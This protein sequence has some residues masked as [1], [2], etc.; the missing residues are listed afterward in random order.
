[1]KQEQTLSRRFTVSSSIVLTVLLVIVFTGLFLNTNH[2][3][4]KMIADQ[5]NQL[6]EN[7]VSKGELLGNLTS[8]ITPELVMGGDMFT[9]KTIA[10]Q[11]LAD[12]DVSSVEI[13]DPSGKQLLIETEKA[14]SDSLLVV[15]KVIKTDP[16]KLGIEQEMGKLKITIDQFRLLEQKE[17]FKKQMF[18]KSL[19]MVFFFTLLTILV[20]VLIALTINKILK[21]IVIAPIRRG[22]DFTT[23]VAEEGNLSID[24]EQFFAGV[25]KSVE[26][27][28]L[29]QAIEKMVKAEKDVVQLTASMAEGVWNLSPQSRSEKD[30]LNKSLTVM[31]NQVNETLN[32]VREM[33][34]QVSTVSDQ[35]SS[36]G[37]DLA[38]G[39]S[40]QAMNIDVVTAAIDLLSTETSESASKASGA[41][42]YSETVN[43]NA[44]TG[45]RQMDELNVAMDAIRHSSTSIQ[46][47][48]KTIDD[49]AFQ[50]NLLALNAAVEAAR[51]GQHGKGFAVVADEVR[52]LASRSA[53]AAQE[54]ATLIENS[55][56]KV[57]N[58]IAIAAQTGSSLKEIV[59]GVEKINSSLEDI[60]GAAVRQVNS[61]QEI[62]GKISTIEQ[63]TAR[64]AATAE[65]TASMAQ[66]LSTQARV[67]ED[68]L[69][70]FD[71]ADEQRVVPQRPEPKQIPGRSRQFALDY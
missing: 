69:E 20:N 37:Q 14:K 39:A 58:G 71:L 21:K 51:A 62:K 42:E 4:G 27:T 26:I 32:N 15:E 53:K 11:L 40:E 13:V 1:M 9:L 30:E 23:A 18:A 19:R 49:I 55:N 67:L 3:F 22:I 28:N 45:S 29:T 61:I 46:K 7:Y 47:I 50:T 54:T 41:R 10:T 34:V 24:V 5:E 70:K 65:E 31:I 35:L 44:A 52:N 59:N 33:S 8:K 36:S 38:N 17:E 66:E 60:S 12:E 43:Q 57:Q 25:E 6:R 64:T 2:Q 16:A 56:L 48:I 68:Q 63:V